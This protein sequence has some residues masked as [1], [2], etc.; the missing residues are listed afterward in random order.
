MGRRRAIVV[1]ACVG[2]LV[3]CAAAL[4]GSSTPR[5]AP[6]LVQ[7]AK[8]ISI[9]P[10]GVALESILARM[11][12]TSVV[13]ARI[14]EAPEGPDRDDP[15]RARLPW[16][17]ATVRVPAPAEAIHSLWQAYLVEGALAELI[18]VS[19]D[20]RADL[21][22]A[23]I[24]GVR[25]DGTTMGTI[26]GGIGDAPR[27][28]HFTNQSTPEVTAS[29]RSVLPRYGLTEV[30][31]RIFSPSGPAP[32]LVASTPRPR[33]IFLQ[34]NHL[35]ADLFGNPPLYE[36]YYFELRDEAGTPLVRQAD[37]LRISDRLSWINEEYEGWTR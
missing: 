18:G 23:T 37:A 1:A 4:A 30:S 11:G 22:G 12:Q 19:P 25:G 15:V 28:Q 33:E 7:T 21:G 10:P 13:A 29:L 17:Y 24:D 8:G 6:K 16:L 3:A 20:M 34:W 32:A 27:G 35:I 14:G 31:L 36:G 2:V 26:G 5:S 9:V